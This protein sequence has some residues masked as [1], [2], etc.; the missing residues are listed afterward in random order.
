MNK[1]IAIRNTLDTSVPNYDDE[2]KNKIRL[3]MSNDYVNTKILTQSQLDD[4][5]NIWIDHI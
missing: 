1:C 2:L 4:I 3:E 5:L